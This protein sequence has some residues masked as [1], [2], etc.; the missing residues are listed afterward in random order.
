MQQT[1]GIDMVVMVFN[2]QFILLQHNN[3]LHCW[4][5]FVSCLC[6]NSVPLSQR[7]KFDKL[8]LVMEKQRG[9]SER[10]T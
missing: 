6:K 7:K 2:F 1:I 3:D 9:K 10:K 4:A 8:A 5:H